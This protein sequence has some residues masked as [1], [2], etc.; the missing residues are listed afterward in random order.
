[1]A[2][3]LSCRGA[4]VANG[5][6]PNLMADISLLWLAI[7]ILGVLYLRCGRGFD[8]RVSRLR[9]LFACFFLG[10]FPLAYRFRHSIAF[11]FSRSLHRDLAHHLACLGRMAFVWRQS[12]SPI[13]RLLCYVAEFVSRGIACR[14]GGKM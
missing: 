1:M 13:C 6:A 10:L 3:A 4:S 8:S 11:V 14:L 7:D 9:S 12:L 2:D 5:K